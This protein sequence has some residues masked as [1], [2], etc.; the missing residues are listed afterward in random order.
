[1]RNVDRVLTSNLVGLC[2]FVFLFVVFCVCAM[3][4]VSHPEYALIPLPI[5][6]IAGFVWSEKIS[7]WLDD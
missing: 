1:M 6:Y 7:R 3:M 4:R 2:G 5:P